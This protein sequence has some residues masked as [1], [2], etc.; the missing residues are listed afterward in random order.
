VGRA[1]ARAGRAHADTNDKAECA[2]GKASM[3]TVPNTPVKGI[4]A[5]AI[6]RLDVP[7]R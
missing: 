5:G 2:G 7:A 1:H 3:I 4:G 6:D